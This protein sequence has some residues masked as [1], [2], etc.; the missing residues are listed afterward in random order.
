MIELTYKN[1]LT[2]HEKEEKLN[3]YDKIGKKS[4]SMKEVADKLSEEYYNLLNSQKDYIN[5][6]IKDVKYYEN[7]VLDKISSDRVF[8]FNDIL[9]QNNCRQEVLNTLA[10]LLDNKLTFEICDKNIDVT[11]IDYSLYDKE[12]EET[13]KEVKFLNKEKQIK[14]KELNIIKK[15]LDKYSHYIKFVKSYGLESPVFNN[16]NCNTSLP[17]NFFKTLFISD[18]EIRQLSF[19]NLR[20][21][22]KFNKNFMQDEVKYQMF[23][24]EKDKLKK[25]LKNIS[26]KLNKEKDNLSYYEN[27]KKEILSLKE[28]KFFYKHLKRFFSKNFNNENLVDYLH[29]FYNDENHKFQLTNDIAILRIFKEIKYSLKKDLELTEEFSKDLRKVIREIRLKQYTIR[30]KVLNIDFSKLE[31]EINTFINQTEEKILFFEE[32]KEILLRAE[33]NKTFITSDE[34]YHYIISK[35]LEHQEYF[36]GV[37]YIFKESIG[38]EIVTSILSNFQKEY[39]DVRFDSFIDILLELKKIQ[40]NR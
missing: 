35:F 4:Q 25:D 11:N 34:S 17:D 20:Y 23:K 31:N 14:L 13:K 16:L 29:D 24:M 28:D 39:I 21:Q 26:K 2:I 18:S 12:I 30:K 38:I 33:L 36:Q 15:N 3:I 6:M 7:K 40:I 19:L 1:Y 8:V 22:K 27:L 37:A 10:S 5:K 32:N 9:K